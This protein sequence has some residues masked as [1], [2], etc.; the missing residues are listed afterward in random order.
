MEEVYCRLIS[1]LIDVGDI[2]L[3]YERAIEEAQQSAHLKI[4]K[5]E[6]ESVIC[7]MHFFQ[8]NSSFET[9]SR[10]LHNEYFEV[11]QT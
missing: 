2:K 1:K 8:R 3:Q 9:A 7:N 10:V 11:T 5:F 4:R 6:E